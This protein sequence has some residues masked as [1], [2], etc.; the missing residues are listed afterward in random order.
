MKLKD[1]IYFKLAFERNPYVFILR[2][3]RIGNLLGIVSTS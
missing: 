3:N 2:M 1:K